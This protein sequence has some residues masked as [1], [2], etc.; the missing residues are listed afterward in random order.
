VPA[1]A[2]DAPDKASPAADLRR[3]GPYL[4]VAPGTRDTSP[5]TTR[6]R[7]QGA[8]RLLTWVGFQ[9]VGTGGRV[10]IQATE[11]PV[12]N[13]VPGAADEVV[14]EFPDTRLHSSNDARRLETGM[15]PTAVG[16]VEAQQSRGNVTRVTVKLR[17]TVGYDLHQEGNYVLL[18]FRPPSPATLAPPPP[19]AP[20]SPAP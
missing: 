6:V 5:S 13:L 1:A 3:N 7:S 14:L 2:Q 10:F 9:M 16:W 15:F 11:R 12:Y 19:E 18:D 4:G 20:P 8:V 17:E